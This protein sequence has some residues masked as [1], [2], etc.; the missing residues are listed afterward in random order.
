MAAVL[1]IIAI[2][3]ALLTFAN[4][5]RTD[6]AP[7]A[8]GP[9]DLLT[10]NPLLGKPAPTFVTVDPDGNKVELKQYLGKNVIMLDFWATWCGP[11]IVAMPD[12]DAVAQKY[13]DRGLVFFSVNEGEDPDTVKAFL[14]RG[15][16]DVPVAM[17][18][19]GRIHA[20]FKGKYLPH[21]IL[22]GK[23]GTVQAS[24][25]GFHGNLA[26]ELS[27]EIESLLGGRNL[28]SGAPSQ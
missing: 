18:F 16:F 20:M 11:C 26:E 3:V 2:G 25:L 23:D 27:Q 28:G 6:N 19:D 21:T 4:C 14:S 17:D 10:P 9:P 13:K 12:I 5:R 1:V 7:P 15:N 22:I 24:H 8:D